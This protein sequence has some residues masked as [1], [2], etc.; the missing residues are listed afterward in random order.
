M[1]KK[2][3]N[4]ISIY[5]HGEISSEKD[6]N[7]MIKGVSTDTRDVS[8]GNLF[9]PLVGE[10]FDGHDFLEVAKENGAVASLI[11]EKYVEKARELNLPYIIVSNTLESLQIMSKNYKD[12]IEDLLVIGITGSNGK[13]STKDILEGILSRK[14]KT[15]KTKGNLNN[16]IGVPLTLL[17]LDSDTEVAIVEMGMDG[18][19]QI[20]ELT[21]I[22]KPN[23]AMI[24]NVGKSHLD[25]LKTKENVARAKFEIL[26]GL[27][28]DGLFIYNLDDDTLRN[29]VKEYDINSNVF[30]FGS[31]TNSDYILELI[32]ENSEGIS[33]NF[34][35]KNEGTVLYNLPMIGRHNM[36]NA[37]PCIIIAYKLGMDKELVQFGLENIRETE[38]RNELIIKDEFTILNDAYK[39]NPSSLLAAIDTLKSIDG[40]ENRVA[41]LGDMLDLGEEIKEI[42]IET[43]E[44]IDKLSV[45][46]I[47]TLGEYGK[48]IGEGAKNN[49]GEENI[50]HAKDKSELINLIIDNIKNNSIILVKG[51]RGVALEDVV[52]KLKNI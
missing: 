50:F 22:V 35:Y 21:N 36:Y 15:K 19:D 14:F 47:F 8:I 17:D 39:S 13:T 26:E 24:T 30:T 3:L 5:T 10:N 12:S 45:N 41:V 25:L 52:E 4:E 11:E 43:G 42:H 34:T 44:Q 18:F 23:I 51:S 28:E 2:T 29:V 6:A 48:F 31:N 7:L 27:S 37:A 40:Y 49:I 9:I 33:F 38:M 16:Q 32:K 1:I 20:R 46:Q